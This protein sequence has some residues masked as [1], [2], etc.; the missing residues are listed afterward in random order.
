MDEAKKKRLEEAGWTVGNT[1]EFLG[2]NK[3]IERKYL[4]KDDSWNRSSSFTA[5]YCR[6][7]YNGVFRVRTM[8]DK[9][10]ITI[11]GKTDGITRVEFE[12]EVPLNEAEEML[13]MFCTK[14]FIEK[15]RYLIQH[16]GFTWEVDQFHGDNEGLVVAEVELE[17]EDIIPPLPDW[18]GEEVST[19][20]KYYNYNLIKQPYNTW[21]TS[22]G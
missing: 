1:S 9:G 10:Y 5:F 3:E 17:S 21:G 11:K 15:T 18:V 4:L 19:D 16:E 22:G 2:L 13:E 8:A 12:Y 14:L 7:G 6:Q 20:S